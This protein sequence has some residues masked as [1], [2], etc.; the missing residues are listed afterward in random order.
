[1][2]FLGSG[3]SGNA[4]AV[5]AG[6]STVLVDVGFSARETVKRLAEAGIDPADVAGILLTHE[7]TDHSSG[8]R[9]LAK[10]LGVP[11]YASEGTRRAARLDEIA[12]DP[13]TMV[14][15]EVETIA[16][17]DVIAFDVS[18]DAEEP[19]GFRFEFGGGAVALATDTGTF[20][21]AAREALRECDA[22]GLE[23]NHDVEML[24]TGP[25]PWFLK[26]RIASDRGH[27]SNDDAMKALEQIACDRLHT[28][29]GLHVSRTNNSH[30]VARAMLEDAVERIG[31]TCRTSV[32]AQH[33]SCS[34]ES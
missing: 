14:A 5:S 26:Q 20:T 22:I 3:S 24:R 15:G 10:R 18:H 16:G 7:H 19:F 25:Y 23:C 13:R 1:M 21:T 30:E 33:A 34:C 2:T 11:V 32:L 31:I 29:V 6:T 4:T 17:I 28:I 27:L 9:V 12:A 8:V